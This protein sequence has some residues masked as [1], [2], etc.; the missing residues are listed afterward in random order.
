MVDSFDLRLMCLPTLTF[1]PFRYACD[2]RMTSSWLHEISL[3]M[4]GTNMF[5]PP[6]PL[7]AATVIE[8]KFRT[9]LPV[10]I[11]N[12]SAAKHT[13]KVCLGTFS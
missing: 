1:F 6:S 8:T 5:S 13:V 12:M 4:K 2:D 10:R 3:P 11:G 7:A 9:R